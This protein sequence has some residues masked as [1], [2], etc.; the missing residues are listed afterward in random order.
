[1]L[2]CRGAH[3]GRLYYQLYSACVIFP[4]L[5]CERVVTLKTLRFFLLA[6][7]CGCLIGCSS[8]HSLK[9]I[10]YG[11]VIVAVG[12]SLT[13]G[14]HMERDD[15]YP[16]QLSRMIQ[17]MVVN[18]GLNGMTSAGALA[19]LPGILNSYRPKLVILS[20]GGNDFLQGVNEEVVKK[21][22][23]VM[24]EKMQAQGVQ[25]LLLAQPRPSLIFNVP[26]LYEEIGEQYHIPVDVKT[27]ARLERNNNYKIDTIHFNI[28]GYRT[29][30]ESV[31]ALLKKQG[32]VK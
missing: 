28:L 31:A 21:N 19:A 17:R 23:S 16:Q 12:D 2:V 26:D 32:A 24:V 7:V 22:I 10:G 6:F 5:Y 13:Y 15:A 9:P 4:S 3:V 18:E 1:M 25:V 29:I 11:D 8:S 30:A 20:I 14:Y 27:I